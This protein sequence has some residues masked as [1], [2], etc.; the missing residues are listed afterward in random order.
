[1]KKCLRGGPSRIQPSANRLLDRIK[2][3]FYDDTRIRGFSSVRFKTLIG[4]MQSVSMIPTVKTSDRTFIMKCMI[5]YVYTRSSIDPYAL[6]RL[7]DWI[8]SVFLVMYPTFF[9][10]DLIHCDYLGND[11]PIYPGFEIMRRSVAD[12]SIF[13]HQKYVRRIT[14]TSSYSIGSTGRDTKLINVYQRMWN[15]YKNGEKDPGH[16]HWSQPDPQ[17]IQC[18]SYALRSLSIVRV[19]LSAH[20]QCSVMR[21]ND[22]VLAWIAIIGSFT[23]ESTK[24]CPMFR[25][26]IQ[27][28][29]LCPI[30][31]AFQIVCGDKSRRSVYR[32]LV[33][34]ATS[35]R[36]K[37]VV[38][39]DSKISPLDPDAYTTHRIPVSNFSGATARRILAGMFS[40]MSTETGL[41]NK[42]YAHVSEYI[43]DSW[44]Q[45]LECILPYF[46]NRLHYPQCVCSSNMV[47]R[48]YGGI[49]VTPDVIRSMTEIRPLLRLFI[50]P[51]LKYIPMNDHIQRALRDIRVSDRGTR[52]WLGALEEERWIWL[53]SMA[54][55]DS[56]YYSDLDG[57]LKKWIETLSKGPCCVSWRSPCDVWPSTSVYDIAFLSNAWLHL[58]ERG[59]RRVLRN[60]IDAMRRFASNFVSQTPGV[61]DSAAYDP[62][63]GV[64]FGD[65]AFSVYLHS[66]T[67][68]FQRVLFDSLCIVPTMIRRHFGAHVG[69]IILTFLGNDASLAQIPLK[70]IQKIKQSPLLPNFYTRSTAEPKMD[71]IRSAFDWVQRINRLNR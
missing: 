14:R 12:F 45:A 7:S 52:S 46:G 66:F 69:S 33:N 19:L 21:N 40:C 9:F 68:C 36:D 41:L 24:K 57:K 56:M 71:C 29:A 38:L 62:R 22:W 15:E 51:V 34:V 13:M 37:F 70:I 8:D 2:T 54:K 10:E 11:P 20:D 65:P 61:Q 1:M 47:R 31:A 30:L 32:H 27:S 17:L 60:R 23:H 26:V 18:I 42:E 5:R 50:S 43:C 53:H 49:R 64:V 39:H 55:V 4:C 3:G 28:V 48:A 25:A 59:R 63:L 67:Q 16:V 6:I 44:M 35:A 58:D